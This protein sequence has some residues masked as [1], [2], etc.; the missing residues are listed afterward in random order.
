[1]AT[2]SNQPRLSRMS[3]AWP[4]G[5]KTHAARGRELRG[6][7]QGSLEDEAEERLQA[8]R[9]YM[10]ERYREEDKRRARGAA[11]A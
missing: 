4:C 9:A 6:A 2:S 8:L 5:D 10:R 11:G 1:M 7:G 3:H